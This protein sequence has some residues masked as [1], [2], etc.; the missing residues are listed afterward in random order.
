VDLIQAIVNGPNGKDTLII[1][2]YDE[3]G[4]SWDHLPPPPYNPGSILATKSDVWAPVP[5]FPRC[6]SPK[7][8]RIPVS[9]TRRMTPRRFSN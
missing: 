1:V 2:T 7:N 8:S 4:G 6:S 3:F 5:V 9:I